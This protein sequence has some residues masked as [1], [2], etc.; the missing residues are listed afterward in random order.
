MTIL[1]LL[2]CLMFDYISENVFLFLFILVTIDIVFWI[3][4][5]RIID[6]NYSGMEKQVE[7]IIKRMNDLEE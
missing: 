5:F 2:F 7:N 1:G 3:I 4:T 6:K